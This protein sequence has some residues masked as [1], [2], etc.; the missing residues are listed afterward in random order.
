MKPNST[1]RLDVF[2]ELNR[3]YP[4]WI[5][6]DLLSIKFCRNEEMVFLEMIFNS[7]GKPIIIN[8][9]FIGNDDDLNSSLFL[10]EIDIV[11]NAMVFVQIDQYSLLM[12]VDG[13][14][15]KEAEQIIN[16]FVKR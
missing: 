15:T 3:R 10:P 16:S 6:K 7:S 9:D 8:L 1:E 11:D 14:F 12:C 4:G 5:N 13:L 2:N